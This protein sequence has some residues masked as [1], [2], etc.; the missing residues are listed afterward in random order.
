MTNTMHKIGLGIGMEV[1]RQTGASRLYVADCRRFNTV[2]DLFEK[3]I[4]VVGFFGD[5]D[6]I[7]K[8]YKCILNTNLNY[9]T[10]SVVVEEIQR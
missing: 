2:E 1:K 3:P 10:I 6:F 8:S 5:E 9:S 7:G 4:I